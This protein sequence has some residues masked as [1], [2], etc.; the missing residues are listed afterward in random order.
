MVY[1]LRSKRL[2]I[3]QLFLS[4]QALKIPLAGKS[5]KQKCCGIYF[6]K[7]KMEKPK[8]KPALRSLQ[9]ARQVLHQKK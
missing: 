8:R 7:I 1:N 3:D 6:P 5:G 4:A 2:K 9:A